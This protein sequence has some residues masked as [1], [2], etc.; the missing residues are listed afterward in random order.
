MWKKKNTS[1]III[2]M[3]Y[4]NYSKKNPFTAFPPFQLSA[5]GLMLLWPICIKYKYAY[6]IYVN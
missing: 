2:F 3:I 1:M 4:L 5:L 6:P